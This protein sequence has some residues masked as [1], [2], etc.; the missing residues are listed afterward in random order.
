[1]ATAFF[2]M[3]LEC[4]INTLTP[5]SGLRQRKVLSQD[6]HSIV[7]VNYISRKIVTCSFLVAST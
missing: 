1:M 4:T 3:Y 5:T 7:R 2:L 6:G